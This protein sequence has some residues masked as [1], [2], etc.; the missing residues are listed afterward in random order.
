MED[1]SKWLEGPIFDEHPILSRREDLF[2]TRVQ[3]YRENHW[4]LLELIAAHT[5]NVGDQVDYG[6]VFND[7]LKISPNPERLFDEAW[8]L[9]RTDGVITQTNIAPVK[10]R[11]E[12]VVG[13][14]A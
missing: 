13:P 5:R 4:L 11:L 8:D 9:L 6:I 1:L 12:T 7:F 10:L 14:R 2:Q 3:S